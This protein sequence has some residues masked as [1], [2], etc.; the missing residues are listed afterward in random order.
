MEKRV[1]TTMAGVA[2]AALM[3][4]SAGVATAAQQD[5]GA[6][7][8]QPAANQ[9]Q[10]KKAV[11]GKDAPMTGNQVATGKM[12]TEDRQ[13][14][15]ATV[16]SATKVFKNVTGKAGDVIP[17]SVMQNAAG[18][19]IIPEVIKAGLLVGGRHGTGV[20]LEKN[21]GDWSLPVFVSITGG[22]LGAQDGVESSDLILVFN[23]KE[24][25]Q[26]ILK[27]SDFTLGADASVVAG[28]TGAKA[29]ASTKDAAVMAY[30]NTEGLFAG[31]SV[32]GSVLTLNEESTTAYYN[33][34]EET[35]RG[36]YGSEEKLFQGIVSDGNQMKNG[37]QLIQKVPPSAE[38]LREALKHA[39][40]QK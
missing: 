33:L 25:M 30:T 39:T 13:E 12:S 15:I 7:N 17:A 23:K 6:K 2:T 5:A 37:K 36:Y 4:F 18:V 9:V 27:G 19:V 16:D 26:E 20:L 21:Q 40:I 29:N 14:A 22:S 34:D 8:T 31:A 1:L 32:T 24:N 11:T 28:S 35:A 38:N 3:I 10:H